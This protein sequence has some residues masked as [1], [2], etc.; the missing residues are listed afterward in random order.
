[1]NMENHEHTILVVDD[2]PG[3][4]DVIAAVLREEYR[5]LAATDS[6]RAFNL[7]LNNRPDL[8]LLDVI[9]PDMDG[10]DL[11]RKLKGEPATWPIPVIFVTAMG[12]EY[13]EATGFEA[14]GVDYIT[15]PVKPF[16]L[17]A[18][19]KTHIDL[20]IKT[21]ILLKLSNM[22]GL[23]GLANRRMLDDYLEKEWNRGSRSKNSLM[24]IL[25]IDV[26]YFK[27]YND[28]YGHQA[29][30]ECLKKI[31]RTIRE[32]LKRPTDLTAR[33][34]GEEF[35]CILPDTSIEGA[36]HLARRIIDRIRELDIPHE[37]SEVSDRVTVSIGAASETI[38][39]HN[40]PGALVMRADNA[41]YSAKRSGRNRVEI[42]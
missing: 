31:A 40:T 25:M 20:K 3:N 7:A 17:R 41:L 19:V 28:F 33:Y 29:G 6:A 24:S 21:D 27:N 10:Y 5:I 13:F 9:M 12:E 2:E 39:I 1:M 15:K 11:C 30:D 26:D 35:T 4:I 18:R 34:G 42:L 38:T 37:R 8:I 22:D 36:G 14:G 23:T 32:E 16:V